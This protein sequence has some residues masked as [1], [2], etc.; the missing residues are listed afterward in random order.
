MKIQST[1]NLIQFKS[2]KK[3]HFFSRNH[4]LFQKH[5]EGHTRHNVYPCQF[6]T[7]I[8]TLRTSRLTHQKRSHREELKHLREM[9]KLLKH[10][11]TAST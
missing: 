11:A 8:F 10:S 6:C 1:K 3:N 4:Y 2:N 7:K 9:R 5:E